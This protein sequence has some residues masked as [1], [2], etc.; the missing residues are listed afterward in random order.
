MDAPAHVQSLRRLTWLAAGALLW[1]A[2]ILGKLIWLQIISH[3]EYVR[4][5]RQQQERVVEIPAPRGSIFDR[6]GRPLAM[7]V[8][9]E[10]VFVNPVRVPDLQV[11]TGL[12]SRLLHLNRDEFADRLQQAYEGHRGFLWVKRKISRTE[13]DRL[14]SLNLGWIGFQAENQ[15]HYP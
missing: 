11:A 10:S 15:R 2:L 4:L 1:A 8:P 3:S 14:R 5:A 7:S 6:N 9:M 12:L 13:A